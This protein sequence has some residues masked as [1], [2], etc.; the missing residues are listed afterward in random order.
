MEHSHTE[1]TLREHLAELRS[2]L[3]VSFAAVA[4]G[5]VITYMYA[6]E[7]GAFLFRPLARVLPADSHLIFTSYQ[8]GFFFYLKLALAGGVIL[9]SPVIF[10]QIWRFIAPGL[11]QNEKR[12]LIPF[13]TLSMFCLFAGGTFAY[14]VVFTPAFRFLL[15]YSTEFLRPMPSVSEYFS[16]CLRLLFSFGMIFELPVLAVFCA[17]AGIIDS[18]FLRRHRKYAF[19]LSF[20]VAAILTPTPDVVNQLLMVAPIVVLYE[21]SILA[22]ALFGR[23]RF[24]GMEDDAPDESGISP[25]DEAVALRTGRTATSAAESKESITGTEDKKEG[26]S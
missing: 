16:L 25:E 15:G 23:K 5:F 26:R 6:R 22:V 11:Y 20:V 10:S 3:V 8:E 19:L 9:G 4:V 18:A 17:K 21:V 7:L 14:L 12:V 24:F 1:Q 2:C 13:T